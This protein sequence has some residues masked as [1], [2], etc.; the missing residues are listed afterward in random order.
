[1]FDLKIFQR[2]QA[3][4]KQCPNCTSCSIANWILYTI[5]VLQ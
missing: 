4:K 1:M 2:K 5:R 3:V